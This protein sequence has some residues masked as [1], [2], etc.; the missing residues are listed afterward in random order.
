MNTIPLWHRTK[1]HAV[2]TKLNTANPS[3]LAMFAV[4][5][6]SQALEALRKER[7]VEGLFQHNLVKVDAKAKVATFKNLADGGKE[8]EREFGFLHAVPPQKPWDWV[9]KSPLGT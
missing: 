8:V 5:K 2:E 3:Y 6:Y 1:H 7:N 9:A 4:P